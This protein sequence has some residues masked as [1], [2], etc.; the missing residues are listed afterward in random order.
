MKGLN[1]ELWMYK[2]NTKKQEGL[3]LFYTKWSIYES[4]IFYWFKKS[5]LA[6]K[7]VSML[8]R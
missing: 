8:Y 6:V 5:K 2:L 4:S 7:Q 1:R 3:S